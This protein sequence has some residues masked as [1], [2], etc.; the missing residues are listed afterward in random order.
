MITDRYG[1]AWQLDG[2]AYSTD[3]I[4]FDLGRTL[5]DAEALDRMNAMKPDGWVE[6]PAVPQSVPMGKARLALLAT[7][8][9]PQVTNAIAAMPG[10]DGDRARIRWEFYPT[11]ERHDFLVLGLAQVFNWTDDQLDALFVLAAQQ[12]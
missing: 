8:L 7:G 2:T 4:S 5:S 11:V 3:G 10:V 9:L 12:Q 6:P 1:R